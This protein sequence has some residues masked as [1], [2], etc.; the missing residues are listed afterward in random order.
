MAEN[1][2]TAQQSKT[3]L[4]GW[5]RDYVLNEKSNKKRVEKDKIYF[6]NNT[7]YNLKS[8]KNISGKKIKI[9]NDKNDLQNIKSN[10]YDKNLIM[11]YN[12][13]IQNYQ[14]LK[15]IPSGIHYS[16]QIK[17][18]YNPKNHQYYKEGIKNLNPYNST[19]NINNNYGIYFNNIDKK[20]MLED[21]NKFNPRKNMLEDYNKFNPRK[22]MLKNEGKIKCLNGCNSNY[23]IKAFLKGNNRIIN[24]NQ[25]EAKNIYSKNFNDKQ[26]RNV[27]NQ[28][29]NNFSNKYKKN[30]KNSLF[31]NKSSI[32]GTI[33]QSIINTNTI[34]N[35]NSRESNP[36][37]I[38]SQI[39]GIG[40]IKDYRS[41]K[42]K[43][44]PNGMEDNE[45]NTFKK[46]YNE[47][48][49]EEYDNVVNFNYNKNTNNIKYI[50]N[51]IEKGN[52][53]NIIE[54]S[55]N[56]IKDEENESKKI[57]NS[58]ENQRMHIKAIIDD[59]FKKDK[60]D[61]QKKSNISNDIKAISDDSFKEDK[62]NI[63][64]KSINCKEFNKNDSLEL[65]KIKPITIEDDD[66]NENDQSKKKETSS[67]EDR[68]GNKI[69]YIIDDD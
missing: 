7:N 27:E 47:K 57:S 33:S 24:K 38:K 8:M 3:I 5:A 20:N 21:Y 64:K 17:Q 1:I 67:N 12:S 36:N 19:N 46:Y 48:Y 56:F 22:N 60:G 10:K 69:K 54:E 63:E 4:S 62:G 51:E 28:Y 43:G 13:K 55:H 66:L 44:L 39:K 11:S 65:N 68:F 16:S 61:I 42:E 53:N 23:P 41:K 52:N 15:K 14:T 40:I 2:S 25:E 34:N 26:I 31:N 37:L 29:Q 50:V 6:N 49:R 45:Q 35:Y 58:N 18:H 30:N 9:I 59:S 32:F